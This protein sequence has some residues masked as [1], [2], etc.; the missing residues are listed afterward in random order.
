MLSTSSVRCRA[1]L[2]T[3]MLMIMC[4]FVFGA[5]L[6]LYVPSLV[7]T[8]NVFG[9]RVS[10]VSMQLAKSGA[11]VV[12]A[13]SVRTIDG[14]QPQNDIAVSD[15]AGGESMHSA[16]PTHERALHTAFFTMRIVASCFV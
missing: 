4:T 5:E 3:S 10:M 11:L 9:A 14:L 7:S 13:G 15:N 12:M 1:W 8:G 6:E 16:D 2:S